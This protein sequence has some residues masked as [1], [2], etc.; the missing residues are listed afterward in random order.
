MEV[1]LYQPQADRHIIIRFRVFNEGVGFRYE[2]PQQENLNFFNI[3]EEL[4]TFPLSG[5]HQA[6]WLPGDYITEEYLTTSSLISEVRS[7]HDKGELHVGDNFYLV[8]NLVVQ[9]DHAPLL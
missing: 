6:F 4:T 3:K 7:I 2:F 5:D 8:N 1:D 9:A